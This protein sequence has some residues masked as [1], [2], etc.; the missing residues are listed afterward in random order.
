M[1]THS[2][3]LGL[4]VIVANQARALDPL[5]AI[6]R[7]DPATV[8]WRIVG[9]CLF[10]PRVEHWIPLAWVETSPSG[11][12]SHI[13]GIRTSDSKTSA[14]RLAGL[15][16]SSAARVLDF[17]N[18]LWRSS[19]IAIAHQQMVCN[20]EDA[21]VPVAIE[22][23]YPRTNCEDGLSVAASIRQFDLSFHTG[24]L[25]FLNTG[26]DSARDTGWSSGCRDKPQIEE[27]VTADMRCDTDFL[28]SEL[29]PGGSAGQKAAGK[30]CLGKWG[31]LIPRQSRE[32]GL[33]GPLASAKTAFR[34]MSTA[35]HHL[36]TFPYP[37]DQSGKMQLAAPGVSGSF[38]PGSKPLP[39]AIQPNA[40]RTY[41]WIYWRKVSCC[42]GGGS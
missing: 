8:Q 42:A 16:S 37:V 4:L 24:L 11:Q 20:V 10:T 15:E 2:L 18:T 7:S 35:R 23:G 34:A 32:I 5:S 33:T 30:F 39:S 28:S 36:G 3:L 1:N 22:T 29:Q 14:L 25:P 40:E 9:Q 12:S 27:A 17:S 26:Y 38:V 6:N 21:M 19:N 41:G 13:D 31:S